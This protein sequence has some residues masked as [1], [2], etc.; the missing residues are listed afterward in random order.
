ML[1]NV[2]NGLNELEYR[3]SHFF[4]SERQ[5]NNLESFN[6]SGICVVCS[7]ETTVNFPLHEVNRSSL[8]IFYFY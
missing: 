1:G 7:T 3:C 2:E 5:A 4:N 8:E 6:G